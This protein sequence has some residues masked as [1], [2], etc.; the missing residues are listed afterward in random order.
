M[1]SNAQVC[2]K[3][4]VSGAPDLLLNNANLYHKF[5]LI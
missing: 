3:Y 5:D 4:K 2:S 1:A